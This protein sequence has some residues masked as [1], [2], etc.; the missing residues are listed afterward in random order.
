ME[1]H[2]M[3]V[4]NLYK[5]VMSTL[6]VKEALKAEKN[7]TLW[8]SSSTSSVDKLDHR[9]LDVG[10]PCSSFNKRWVMGFLEKEVNVEYRKLCVVLDTSLGW[11]AISIELRQGY[12]DL[13][14]FPRTSGRFY[15][16]VTTGSVRAVIMAS[17]PLGMEIQFLPL[18]NKC[19]GSI[20][21][22]MSWKLQV[23]PLHGKGQEEAG[24][25][26]K[27]GKSRYSG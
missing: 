18:D 24:K 25:C 2:G 7:P 22:A 9:D 8:K 14:R 15:W 21:M 19:K 3:K 13:L 27:D 26:F 20:F 10:V 4:V 11:P 1:D 23:Y 5:S 12:P 6:P 17:G 16:L